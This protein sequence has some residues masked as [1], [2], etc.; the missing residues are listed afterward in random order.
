MSFMDT[1][2][3]RFLIAVTAAA[4]AGLVTSP[5]AA[6]HVMDG[7]LPSTF[8]QGLLS[9][10]GHPVIGLDH[11]AFVV[12][13]GIAAAAV[14]GS[15]AMIAVFVALS[16]AGVLFH[17]AE[18]DVPMIEPLVAVTVMLAGAALVW[19]RSVTRPLWIALAA[20]A[21]L[22]HGYAFGE[23]IVGAERAVLGAYIVGIALVTALIATPVM[24]IARRVLVPDDI[25]SPGLKIAGVA[26]GGIGAVL[27]AVT[28]MPG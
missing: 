28:L 18:L 7:R 23:S 14:S 6:H 19:N 20:I 22:L 21:G 16:A 25:P 27:L 9:G 2:R 26:F 1:R 8:V 13:L 4:I 12:A 24:M 11:L 3:I 15:L 5:A 10:L 17:V